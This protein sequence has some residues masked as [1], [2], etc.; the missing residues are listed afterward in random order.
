[1][2]VDTGGD[3]NQTPVNFWERMGKIKLK[4]SYLKLRQFERSFLKS[5]GCFQG[6]LETNNRFEII[7]ITAEKYKKKSQGLVGINVLKVDAAKLIKCEVGRNWYMS[8]WM[9][10]SEYS[11]KRKLS[12]LFESRKTAN[13]HSTFSCY[14]TKAQN[15]RMWNKEFYNMK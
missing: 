11:I 15:F 1:M 9:V 2:Q 7:P 12:P 8:R 4:K 3:V 5:L 13:S 14:K 10:E 6:T